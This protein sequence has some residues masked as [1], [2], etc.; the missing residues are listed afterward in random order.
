VLPE[1]ATGK[2]SQATEQELEAWAE[3]ILTAQT[4]EAV[5]TP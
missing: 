2:L 4:L 1:W 5:F 3:A